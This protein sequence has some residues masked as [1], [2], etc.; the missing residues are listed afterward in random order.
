MA[1]EMV[2]Y[3]MAKSRSNAINIMIELG[4]QKVKQELDFW[5]KISEGVGELKKNNYKM[6]HG[7]LSK[8]LE[9]ERQ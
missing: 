6:Q 5:K 8:I 4:I 1:D 2:R 7:G 3:G 9:E